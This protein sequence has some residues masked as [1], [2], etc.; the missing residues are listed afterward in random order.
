MCV[1]SREWM[2]FGGKAFFCFMALGFLSKKKTTIVKAILHL[3]TF[4]QEFFHH[5]MRNP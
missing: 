1:E 2:K 5:M 4:F 3:K